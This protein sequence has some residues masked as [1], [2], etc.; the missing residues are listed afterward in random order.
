MAIDAGDKKSVS[1]INLAVGAGINIFEIST[2]GQPFEVLK[3]H[4]AANRS[5]GLITAAQK[6]FQRG[7]IFGFYQGLIPWYIPPI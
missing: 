2:L 6:T 5:D 1:W 7:G 3:T 4:M